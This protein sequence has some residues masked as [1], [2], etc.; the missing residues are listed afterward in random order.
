[1]KW[2]QYCGFWRLA[3]KESGKK[4]GQR[5][6]CRITVLEEATTTTSTTRNSGDY[7]SSDSSSEEEDQ[8]LD[9]ALQELEGLGFKNMKQNMRLLSK[10]DGNLDAV[11]A[12][13]NKK[14]EKQEK[15]EKKKEEQKRK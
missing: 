4:F 7:S 9:E 8:E 15:R 3:D 13:L 6:Q 11:I 5:I 12:K 1:M 14:K 10:F 2:L